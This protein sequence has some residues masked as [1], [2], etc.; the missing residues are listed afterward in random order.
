MCVCVRAA[1][2]R[3]RLITSS[4][5]AVGWLHLD[6]P[7]HLER[8]TESERDRREGKSQVSVTMIGATATICEVGREQGERGSAPSV[9]VPSLSCSVS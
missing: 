1:E 4:S 8:E 7:V 5:F 6:G 3:R 2:T 9:N